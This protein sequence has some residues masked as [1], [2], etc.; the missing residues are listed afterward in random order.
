[1]SRCASSTAAL[2]QA[3]ADHL[4]PVLG[5]GAQDAELFAAAQELGPDPVSAPEPGDLGRLV[6]LRRLVLE[7]GPDGAGEVEHRGRRAVAVLE[8]AADRL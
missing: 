5:Q 3:G 1:M 4:D 8:H 6:D 2:L 7:R